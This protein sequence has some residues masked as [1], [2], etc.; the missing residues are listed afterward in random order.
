MVSL[1]WFRW[2]DCANISSEGQG[3][4]AWVKSHYMIFQYT[5]TVPDLACATLNT[6]VSIAFIILIS[7]CF[8]ILYTNS[9][10][11][12]KNIKYWLPYRKP[13]FLIYLGNLKAQ[14]EPS[15]AS[16]CHHELRQNPIHTYCPCQTWW[17][18]RSCFSRDEKCQ[19][20]HNPLK[21]QSSLGIQGAV[22]FGATH[23]H[24]TC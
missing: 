10:V 23:C 13:L 11:K 8:L 17:V 18:P 19:N 12:E 21:K 2:T 6:Q 7:I 14:V 5:A 22:W 24:T 9:S 4:Q 16:L 20:V 1:L 15:M 3:Y